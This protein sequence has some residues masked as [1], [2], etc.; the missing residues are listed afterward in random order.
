MTLTLYP[1]ADRLTRDLADLWEIAS[2]L[3]ATITRIGWES[4][5]WADMGQ[6]T[7]GLSSET[8][9]ITLAERLSEERYQYCWG[10]GVTEVRTVTWRGYTLRITNSSGPTRGAP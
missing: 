1:Y 10:R 6:I 8:A 2:D 7:V 3:P 5:G 4:T 9:P